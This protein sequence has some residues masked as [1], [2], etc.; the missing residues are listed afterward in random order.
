MATASTPPSHPNADPT[1]RSY[2]ASQAASY[3]KHRQGHPPL[4]INSIIDTHTTNGL[5][6][7]GTIVDVGCGPGTATRS[8]ALFF[9]HA[10]GLDPGASMINTATHLGGT[11]K[12]GEAIMYAVASAEEIDAKLTELGVEEGSVDMITAAT[13]CHWFD[14]PKF[15]AAAQKMLRSGGSIA[16]WTAGG[17]YVDKRFTPHAEAVQKLLDEFELEIL[18]L[19]ELPG[20]R[21]ARELYSTIELPWTSDVDGYDK[22][23]YMYRTWNKDGSLEEGLENGWLQ[24]TD[25]TWEG[26]ALMLGTASPV[27][28]WREANK[29]KVEKGEVRDCVEVLVGQAHSVVNQGNRDWGLEYR[30]GDVEE[31]VGFHQVVGV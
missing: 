30:V 12:S 1:F 5:G 16:L 29:S 22:E 19:H 2:A 10:F 4:L 8:L 23:S 15:Y 28:R 3:A 17:W 18:R 7:L 27:T 6:Q 9:E 14:L 26:M 11:A 24:L 21:L 25:G 31:E 13:A 20:N